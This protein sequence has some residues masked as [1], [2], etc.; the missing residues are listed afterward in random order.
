VISCTCFIFIYDKDKLK[1]PNWPGDPAG[2]IVPTPE[3]RRS[4]S[5][6]EIPVQPED[7]ARRRRRILISCCA[8]A[9]LAIAIASWIYKRNVES[10]RAM[11]SYDAAVRLFRIARYNQA[12][13][14]LD[15][16][17]GLKPDFADG[18]L[19]R[20][21]AYAGDAI[22]ELAIRDFTKVLEIRPSDTAARLA[23]TSVYIDRKDYHSAIADATAVLAIDPSLSQAYNFRACAVRALGDP[24]KALD[25]FNRAVQLNQNVDNYYQRAATYQILGEH[26]LAIADLDQVIDLRPG[27][28]P[29]YF[30]RAKSRQAAGDLRGADADYRLGILYTSR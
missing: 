1:M 11:E 2:T 30:A 7:V 22:T 4:S 5:L 16:T 10:L 12:I 27:Q 19:L 6:I 17:I 15:L 25:D 13:I 14:A 21:R 3:P 23:R 18:Y 8:A 9:L 26:R 24:K 28:A 20:G 29:V